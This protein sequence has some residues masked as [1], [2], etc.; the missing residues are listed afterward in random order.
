MSR[1]ADALAGVR[2]IHT[3][4]LDVEVRAAEAG[5]CLWAIRGELV[6]LRKA[7][8]F[9]IAADLQTA[10]L[11]H[12]M[13]VSAHFDARSRTLREISAEQP[14]VAFEPSELSEGDHCR[15]PVSRLGALAGVALTPGWDA[16]LLDAIGG[17]RGCSH[18]L[19]LARLAG[20][21]LAWLVDGPA[22][23]AA[24]EWRAGERLFHRSLCFDGAEAGADAIALDFQ[25]SDLHFAAAPSLA[26]PLA[27]L[28]AQNEVRGR[29]LL[30]RDDLDLRE[31]RAAVRQRGPHDLETAGWRDASPQLQRLP[32][33]SVTRGLRRRV[34]E[35]LP[36][37][38][39]G[40]PLAAALLDLAPAALQCLGSDCDPWAARAAGNP[41]LVVAG[42]AA[43]SCW[44][45]RAD[46]PLAR[47][48][49]RERQRG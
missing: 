20:A 14:V 39:P 13:R 4:S 40:S 5:A 27:R 44:M 6:D 34:L 29:A 24:A 9:P 25:L 15:A 28:A 35:S 2:P 11:L 26:R 42:G 16:R 41:S 37:E 17:P 1:S 46:G 48:R 19:S 47:A 43:D 31:L 45:W 33:D 22:A 7:G 3:R 32:G 38:A 18:V 23:P 8:F 21:T 36:G 12:H 49:D 30:G 10:G